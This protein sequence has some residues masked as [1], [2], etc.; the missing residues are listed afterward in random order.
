MKENKMGTMPVNRLLISMSIPMIISMLVQALYNVVDSM[1]VAQVSENALTAV[2][3]AFPYQNLMI[4]VATGTGVGINALLSKSLGENDKKLVNKTGC[5]AVF[6]ALASWAVFAILGLAFCRTFF[7]MQT[8]VAEIVDGGTAYLRICSVISIGL[9][10]Q[11]AFEKLLAST[12]RTT[13]TMFTQGTGAIIN[14]VLDPIFIFGWFGVPAMGV[15]GAAIA[16][17]IGQLAG[18]SLGIWLNHRYNDELHLSFQGFRPD[19]RVIKKIYSVGVPSILMASIGSIMTFGMN[20][21]LIG[22]STTAAAVFGVY[23]KLQSFIFMPVFGLNN[24][25]V[26]IVAYNYG[27]RRPQRI[28]QTI[29]LSMVYATGMMALGFAAFQLFPQSLLSIFNASDTMLSIGIPALKIISLHFILAGYSIICSSTFQALGH[30]VLSLQMSLARQ[31]VV[32]LPCA[33]V[34]AQ[35]GVLDYVWLAF[36]IAELVS[37]AMGTLFLLRIFKHEIEPLRNNELVFETK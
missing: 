26:P 4:A 10:V 28:I 5:N 32:L 11:I 35:T 22:F 18:A 29:K 9:F 27:A 3:L 7:Q 17:V 15:A 23:F 34:F 1:F 19:T 21:I 14:I 33:F 25:L 6:L 20:K 2:S 36:P 16:T 24:G 31:L 12:G 30:G 13:L 8:G 37:V